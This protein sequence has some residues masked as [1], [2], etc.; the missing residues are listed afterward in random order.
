MRLEDLSA[1]MDKMTSAAEREAVEHH[2][3]DCESCREE[4]ESLR[5]MVGLLRRVPMETPRRSFILAEAPAVSAAPQ[6]RR[7]PAWGYAAA[8]SAA[9][10]VFAVILT[11]DLS[12]S[13]AGDSAV[14]DSSLP[15][16]EEVV[17]ESVAASAAEIAV[18]KE[19]TVELPIVKAAEIE[20][21]KEAA[22]AAPLAP[23]E[24]LA[25]ATEKQVVVTT[26]VEQEVVVEMQTVAETVEERAVAR[27]AALSESAARAT[28]PGRIP[29]ALPEEEA[30]AP[31]DAPE[32]PV[33]M[34]PILPDVGAEAETSTMLD[35]AP[36]PVPQP[37]DQTTEGLLAEDAT[38]AAQATPAV[39]SEEAPELPADVP[40]DDDVVPAAEATEPGTATLW[41]IIEGLLAGIAVLLAAVLI[42]RLWRSRR[43]A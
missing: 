9:A 2:L 40:I 12:G 22:A 11:A 16:A 29:E 14:P 33:A 34:A 27:E 25:A 39:E 41:R 35:I 1:Y 7:M 36:T 28:A 23:D 32:Q 6:P 18:E 17:P 42:R 20:A 43:V 38:P 24:G 15:A 5:Q 31:V 3:A 26:E 19:E 4:L 13:L 8:T 21:V 10:L 30:V 37:R